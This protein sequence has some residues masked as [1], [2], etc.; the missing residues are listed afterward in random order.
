MSSPTNI[1]MQNLHKNK[2]NI[3]NHQKYN[4]TPPPKYFSRQSLPSMLRF[5]SYDTVKPKGKDSPGVQHCFARRK[6]F[7]SA[8]YFALFTKQGRNSKYLKWYKYAL[9]LVV[10]TPRVYLIEKYGKYIVSIKIFRI[11]F[12][13]WTCPSLWSASCQGCIEIRI[14]CW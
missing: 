12:I 14:Q 7:S 10:Q 2:N 4:F 3:S 5:T 8:I 13:G 9:D 11:G 1:T 6:I